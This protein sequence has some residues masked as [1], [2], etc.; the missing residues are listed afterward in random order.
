MHKKVSRFVHE[1]LLYSI[2][3]Q[4]FPESFMYKKTFAFIDRHIYSDLNEWIRQQ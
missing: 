1:V 2:Y 4:F 3:L